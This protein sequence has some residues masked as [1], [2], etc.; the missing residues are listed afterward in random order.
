M[1]SWWNR[2]VQNP[3]KFHGY[4]GEQQHSITLLP[5]QLTPPALAIVV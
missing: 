5:A 2:H 4:Q 3:I 1:F